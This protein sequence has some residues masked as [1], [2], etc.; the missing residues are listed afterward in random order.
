MHV[1]GKIET[2][3]IGE[4]S[5]I[6]EIPGFK[7]FN[8]SLKFLDGVIQQVNAKGER[9]KE[10]EGN[11]DHLVIKIVG[12][13]STNYK[14]EI[15]Y[16]EKLALKFFSGYSKLDLPSQEKELGT[17]LNLFQKIFTYGVYWMDERDEEWKWLC[18]HEFEDEGVKCWPADVIA[19]LILTLRNDLHSALKYELYTIRESLLISL[20]LNWA[21]GKTNAEFG[22]KSVSEYC[23]ILS[24]INSMKKEEIDA[25]KLA[26]RIGLKF[27]DIVGAG[28]D[29]WY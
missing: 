10:E 18:V 25:Y 29:D 15:E 27:L 21:I 17:L 28:S 12:E 11:F 9:W 14:I 1:V 24:S 22:I 20:P 19:S 2:T 3:E 16:N 8:E 23:D 5:S 4:L 13:S 26:A 7:P 6:L